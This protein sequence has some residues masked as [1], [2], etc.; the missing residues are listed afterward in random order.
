MRARYGSRP[1][2]RVTSEADRE[3]LAGRIP[4]RADQEARERLTSTQR[5]RVAAAFPVSTASAARA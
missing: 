3:S 5:S 1:A 4:A 2:A